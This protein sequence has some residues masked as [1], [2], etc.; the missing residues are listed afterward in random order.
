MAD[1]KLPDVKLEPAVPPALGPRG[2]RYPR[3]KVNISA[4]PRTIVFLRAIADD[5]GVPRSQVVEKLVNTA[6]RAMEERKYFCIC[7]DACPYQRQGFPDRW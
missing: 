7:G 3:T 1:E 6:R 5:L 4:H 2:K